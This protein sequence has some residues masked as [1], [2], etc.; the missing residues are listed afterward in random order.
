MTESWQNYRQGLIMRQKENKQTTEDVESQFK[1]IKTL[2]DLSDS[3]I[4]NDK[5]HRAASLR[6][7]SF[8][9]LTIIKR[10]TLR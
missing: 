2:S 1:G 8:F 4:F 5:E 3:K 6:Y 9:K 10:L 7:L